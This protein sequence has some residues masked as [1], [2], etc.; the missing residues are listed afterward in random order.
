MEKIRVAM[1]EPDPETAREI[2]NRIN[3]LTGQQ[4]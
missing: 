3:I 4:G 2:I 1:R